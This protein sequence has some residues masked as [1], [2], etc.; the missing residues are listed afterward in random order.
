MRAVVQNFLDE[1]DKRHL[2]YRNIEEH[3]GKTVVPLGFGLSNLRT[4]IYVFFDEDDRS[5][6]IR[7]FGFMKV[8]EN[9]F[10]QALICCNTLNQ[11]KRW[12]KFYVDT[13]MEIHA[14]DDAIIEEETAGSEILELVMRMANIVDEAYPQIN[15]A[16]WS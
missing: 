3:N 5:V 10:P 14:S 9:Q 16:I 13:D 15:R 2:S 6:A 1:L 8:S 11:S 7:C 12:V 4:M